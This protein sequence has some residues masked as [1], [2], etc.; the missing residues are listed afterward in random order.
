MPGKWRELVTTAASLS[1]M[2]RAAIMSLD[3]VKRPMRSDVFALGFSLS[4]CARCFCHICLLALP[5]VLPAA[6]ETFHDSYLPP[7]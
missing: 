5:P 3:D 4:W 2:K 1:V 6:A 7:R